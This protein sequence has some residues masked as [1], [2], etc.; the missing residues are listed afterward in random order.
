MHVNFD[1]PVT[2]TNLVI[3]RQRV[4]VSLGTL[5]AKNHESQLKKNSESLGLL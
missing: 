3:L 5:L 4:M 2:P 1:L